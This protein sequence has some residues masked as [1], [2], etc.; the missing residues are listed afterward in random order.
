MGRTYPVGSTGSTHL[1]LPGSWPPDAGIIGAVW[2]V[3]SVSK[4][5]SRDRRS[6]GRELLEE[7]YARGEISCEEYLKK[8]RYLEN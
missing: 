1:S 7:R 2:L 8:K 4:T 5:R 3:V 6:P